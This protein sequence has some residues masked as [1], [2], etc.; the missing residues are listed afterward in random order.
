[1][2]KISRDNLTFN[3]VLPYVLLFAGLAGMLASFSLT[4]E[5]FHLLEN[6]DY[7][8]SCSLSPIVSCESSLSAPLGNLFGV[9]VTLFGMMAFTALAV[10][11]V[12]LA[13]GAKFKRWV[14]LCAQAAALG[15]LVWIVSFITYSLTVSGKICPWCFLVWLGVIATVWG[16]T[17]YNFREGNFG[18]VKGKVLRWIV[19]HS[20]KNK[21]QILFGAYA[22]LLLILLVRFWDYWV[23]LV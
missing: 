16:V 4:A 17:I 9:P 20:D 14:W 6:P 1:M 8:L 10:F 11:G 21:V 23:S 3:K 7:Q 22:L 19:A 12:L 18:Q 13:S 2:A 15:G 5:K